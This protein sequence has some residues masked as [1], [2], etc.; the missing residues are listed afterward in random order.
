MIAPIG[1]GRSLPSLLLGIAL[2]AL[3]PLAALPAT[4]LA[5]TIIADQQTWKAIPT[6]YDM[7]ALS[8]CKELPYRI[9]GPGQ[10]RL[11]YTQQ[12]AR[13]NYYEGGSA[14]PMYWWDP[15]TAYPGRTSAPGSWQRLDHTT[16]I[17]GKPSAG[18]SDEGRHVSSCARYAVPAGAFE[19]KLRHCPHNWHTGGGAWVQFESRTTLTVDYAQGGS[20]PACA[21]G[22]PTPPP[23][24]TP[25][26]ASQVTLEPNTDRMGSDYR[27]FELNTPD[28]QA[29]RQA[30]QQDP[31]CR[32]F[33]Y[34]RPG[35]QAANAVCYLKNAVPGTR[36]DSCCVS[37]V[38]GQQPGTGGGGGSYTA[39]PPA[40][41]PPE[42]AAVNLALRK[43]AT[44]SSVYGGTG[45]DQGP[46]FGVDGILESQP[47][48]PF[49]MVHTGAD[50][51]AW[52]Q[53][54]LQRVYTLTQ[55]KVYNRKACCQ[56]KARTIQVL[57][58]SDG[59]RWE[60]A[61][62]HNGT[63]FNVLT[64]NLGGRTARYVR[65]QLAEP[66]FLH[67]QECEVYGY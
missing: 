36:A 42:R 6:V 13:L 59:A 3:A 15:S 4:A 28:P 53:V 58:S 2:L 48:D 33:T 43:S 60:R 40:G 56:E 57:L 25:P 29:C 14:P 41:R 31:N 20:L 64:V 27:R 34:V 11:Q 51:P 17:D 66:G 54:D 52:W 1:P 44:Q 61:Y 5:S 8:P 65:L 19:G 55:V 16:L 9:Q 22:G 49:L 26:S 10:L 62:A 50:N 7:K 23:P 47:R 37:G 24:P 30:C 63:A 32:A 39:Q 35:L 12:P 46:H 38:R 21:E 45:V 18:Q 67:F